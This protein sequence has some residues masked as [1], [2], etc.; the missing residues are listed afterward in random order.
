MACIIQE[1]LDLI[2][3]GAGHNALFVEN[4]LTASRQ[5]PSAVA[6][7]A[8]QRLARQLVRSDRMACTSAKCRAPAV[9]LNQAGG[10]DSAWAAGKAGFDSS[11]IRTRLRVNS[12]TRT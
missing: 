2:E 8:W 10:A 6:K 7:T 1:L 5:S 4:P 9:R 12:P 11:P 3:I